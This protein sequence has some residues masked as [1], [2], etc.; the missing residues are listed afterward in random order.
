MMKKEYKSPY[1]E[2]AEMSMSRVLMAS[3]GE[4]DG[5]TK[6]APTT[7]PTTPSEFGAPKRADMPSY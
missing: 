7:L 6:S 3:G 1:T 2:I 5:G 4:F